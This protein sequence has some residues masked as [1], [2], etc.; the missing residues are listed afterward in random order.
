[1]IFF[2]LSYKVESFGIKKHKTMANESKT[3][4]NEL[5]IKFGL[6][7]GVEFY[8]CKYLN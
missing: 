5:E 1:M 6:G 2:N 4:I 7:W 8:S 3:W